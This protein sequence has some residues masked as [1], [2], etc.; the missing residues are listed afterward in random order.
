MKS[1]PAEKES[2]SMTRVNVPDR[3][4]HFQQV[5]TIETHVVYYYA[6]DENIPAFLHQL[7]SVDGPLKMISRFRQL[8]EIKDFNLPGLAWMEE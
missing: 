3:E 8:A 6:T 4:W 1:A 5:G 2:T 7:L